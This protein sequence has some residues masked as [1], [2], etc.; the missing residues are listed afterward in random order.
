MAET[1]PPD[2]SMHSAV[3]T[4]RPRRLRNAC[5][6]WV[7]IYLLGAAHP[8]LLSFRFW[9]AR[10]ECLIP[11]SGSRSTEKGGC[12]RNHRQARDN[13]DRTTTDDRN[14]PRSQ[15]LAR[16]AKHNGII[17][18]TFVMQETRTFGLRWFSDTRC[19]ATT[20]L[21]NG[22]CVPRA[23]RKQQDRAAHWLPPPTLHLECGEDKLLPS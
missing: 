18:R 3:R 22:P 14:T 6:I 10:S 8:L 1:C 9:H 5:A 23:I 17:R 11:Q 19:Q 2:N 13:A 12:L 16:W 21:G 7:E 15:G 4:T 20:R